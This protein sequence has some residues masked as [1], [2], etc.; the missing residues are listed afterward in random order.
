MTTTRPGSSEDADGATSE[1]RGSGSEAWREGCGSAKVNVSGE[2]RVRRVGPDDGVRVRQADAVATRGVCGAV[3]PTCAA[4]QLQFPCSRRRGGEH[5]LDESARILSG[6]AGSLLTVNALLLACA[7]G[8]G[9][10][11]ATAPRAR[12]RSG[13]LG[14]RRERT[15]HQHNAPVALAYPLAGLGL[16]GPDAQLLPGGRGGDVLDAVAL[17]AAHGG[18]IGLD[19]EHLGRG[20]GVEKGLLRQRQPLPLSLGL[21]YRAVR[22]HGS[23]PAAA[24]RGRGR[25]ALVNGRRK[26]FGDRAT[27]TLALVKQAV[28][29]VAMQR[30]ARPTSAWRQVDGRRWRPK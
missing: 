9:L 19:L 15:A 10:R 25:A 29:M 2:G 21:L 22:R 13:G 23:L 14:Q 1:P 30:W 7:R 28:E 11:S 27:Q 6:R 4:R 18:P 3:L 24:P 20:L 12:P 26:H 5:L 8:W 16:L 17:H